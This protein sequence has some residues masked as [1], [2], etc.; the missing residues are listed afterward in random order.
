MT[1]N[2]YNEQ[3]P[4]EMNALNLAYIGDAVYEMY[5]RHHLLLHGG[6]PMFCIRKQYNMFRQ[7]H[8]HIL[9]II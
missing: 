5:I 8:R 1:K 3:K 2:T 4:K 9:Y 7:K 6:K